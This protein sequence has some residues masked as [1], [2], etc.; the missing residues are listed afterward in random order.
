MKKGEKRLKFP[1]KMRDSVKV[2]TIEEL[3]ENFDAEMLLTNYLN[4]KLQKWLEDRFYDE[5]NKEICKLDPSDV[6]I[7]TKLC[8]ILEIEVTEEELTIDVSKLSEENEKITRLKEFT[9]DNYIL[10]HIDQVATNQDE[11]TEMLKSGS[12]KAFLMGTEFQVDETIENIII[13]GINNPVVKV[14]SKVYLDF[15]SKNVEIKD[16]RF[17]E[18]YQQLIDKENGLKNFINILKGIL[19]GKDVAAYECECR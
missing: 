11:F 4:G 19:K 6:E 14:A 3:R 2:R 8:K 12:D 5:Y 18:T 1:L 9:D 15:A 13:T 17:D 16:V 10:E 7:L